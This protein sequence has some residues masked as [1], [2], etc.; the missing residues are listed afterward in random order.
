MMA[1]LATNI[2]ALTNIISLRPKRSAKKPAMT[3]ANIEPPN[4]AAT[5]IDL[6]SSV[7][8]IVLPR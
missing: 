1:T 2:T 4:T 8:E 5:M 3:E 7:M 6:F